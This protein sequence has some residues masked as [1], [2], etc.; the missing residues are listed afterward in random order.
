MLLMWLNKLDNKI[1]LNGKL[2]I[3]KCYWLK[4]CKWNRGWII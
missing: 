4:N 1:N 3:C 2:K